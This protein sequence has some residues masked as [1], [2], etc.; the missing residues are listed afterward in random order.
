MAYRE[1]RVEVGN[2][3]GTITLDRPTKGNSIT[4]TMAA[5][6][7]RALSQYPL[8]FFFLFLFCVFF[9][10]FFFSSSLFLDSL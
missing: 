5:E 1:L 7:K 2:H 6:L 8:F 9:C 10:L 3:R 4:L